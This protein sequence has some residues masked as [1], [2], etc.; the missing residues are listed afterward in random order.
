MDNKTTRNVSF[1]LNSKGSSNDNDYII[2]DEILTSIDNSFE[3]KMVAHYK[4]DGNANDISGNGNDGVV[5]G[6]SLISDRNNLEN[7]GDSTKI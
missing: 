3:N 7:S 2:S 5:N 4:F 6:A 1:K